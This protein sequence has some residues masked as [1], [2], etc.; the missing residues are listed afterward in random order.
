MNEG[1][2]INPVP[3]C[4]KGPHTLVMVLNPFIVIIPDP[5]VAK[6]LAW[7][8][9]DDPI[10]WARDKCQSLCRNKVSGSTATTSLLTQA[11]AFWSGNFMISISK[12]S[13]VKLCY[14]GSLT[15]TGFVCVEWKPVP[16]CSPANFS[17]CPKPGTA[18]WH[19]SDREYT[20]AR[21]TRKT[22]VLWPD[23]WTTQHTS[24]SF[25]LD[26]LGRLSRVCAIQ[27]I[28]SFVRSVGFRRGKCELCPVGGVV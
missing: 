6:N 1:W 23:Q 16:R 13:E 18:L 19:I 15:S 5:P 21:T 7:P 26:T 28:V 9:S 22:N 11:V 24:R 12:S 25:F 8:L 4:K 3:I 14:A 17:I 2:F 20:T 27:R 10:A